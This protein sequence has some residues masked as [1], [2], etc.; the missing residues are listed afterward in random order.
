MK[1]FSEI[2]SL[3]SQRRALGAFIPVFASVAK[4]SF[5]TTVFANE[6]KQ[7]LPPDEDVKKIERRLSAQE[8]K[9]LGEVK[10]IIP[11]VEGK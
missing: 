3:R 5:R 8:K 6:L 2:A 4:Q 10:K 1:N 7:S 9:G 11:G